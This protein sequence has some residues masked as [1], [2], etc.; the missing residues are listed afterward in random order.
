MAS[1]SSACLSRCIVSLFGELRSN[2][3]LV[4]S[5]RK[6]SS[7]LLNNQVGLLFPYVFEFAG[8][9][10]PPRRRPTGASKYPPPLTC[11]LDQ[12]LLIVSPLVAGGLVNLVTPEILFHLGI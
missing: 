12:H 3:A 8:H 9:P 10:L 2:A 6:A 5:Q 11:E 7:L 4:S 1:P